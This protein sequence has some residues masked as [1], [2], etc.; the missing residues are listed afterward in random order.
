MDEK[1]QKNWQVYLLLCADNTFYCGIT[2][3]LIQRLI[4]H[5]KGKGSKYTRGRLPVK[6]IRLSDLM[7]KGEALK[8]E[9]VIKG[10]PKA[11]KPKHNIWTK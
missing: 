7:G 1:S 5:H 8:M 3:H 10:L 6:L 9:R 4:N 11:L 2:N